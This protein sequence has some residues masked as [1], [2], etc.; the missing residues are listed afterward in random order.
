MIRLSFDQAPLE[1]IFFNLVH[2][3]VAY[4]RKLRKSENLQTILDGDND[5]LMNRHCFQRWSLAEALSEHESERISR[6]YAIHILQLKIFYFLQQRCGL[7]EK[8]I[9]SRDNIPIPSQSS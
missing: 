2:V 4:P 1:A 8:Q 7:R 3:G 6:D 9:R 5:N